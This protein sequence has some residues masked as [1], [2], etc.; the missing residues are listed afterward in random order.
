M[1]TSSGTPP[2]IFDLEVNLSSLSTSTENALS[3]YVNRSVPIV[4]NPSD[5]YVSVSRFI[6]STQLIP[7]WSPVLNTTSPYN[8]GYNTIYSVTLTYETFSSEQVF[9]RVINTL[10]SAIPPP[11]PVTS[12]PTNGWGYVYSYY[13][14]CDMIN[15]A[16]AT[17]Y[18]SLLTEVGG[19]ASLDPNPP[20]MTWDNQTQI[21]T[22]NCFPLSQYDQESGADVVGIYFNNNYRQ[23]LLGWDFIAVSQIN[24]PN[25]T[26]N[27]LNIKNMGN[28]YTP[29]SSPPT[30]YPAD[31]D[32]VLLQYQQSI[33]SPWCFCSL[34]KIQIV[35]SL[36][37]AYPTLSALPLAIVGTANNNATNPVVCDFLVNYSS[38]GASS[39][40]QPISYFPALDS[41]SSPIKLAGA[42]VL[43]SFSIGVNWINLEGQAFPLYAFGNTNS[44]IKLTFTHKTLIENGL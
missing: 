11:T 44:S 22:M 17:A 2:T 8:D 4:L 28:N 29:Q 26:D 36:P 35:S 21:F 5:Y 10:D 6:C 18:T 27:L 23:Y 30:Y 14:I 32:T 9:L 20:Y 25:G 38:G 39:F 41:Y 37:I 19:S 13:K 7:L 24:T 33:S 43:N 31:P 3:T 16:L 12:Q 40:A 15:E 1:A 42:S 34:S